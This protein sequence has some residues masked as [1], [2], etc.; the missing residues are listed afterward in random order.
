MNILGYSFTPV[1]VIHAL[2]LKS[3]GYVIVKDNKSVFFTGDVAWIEKAHLKRIGPVDLVVTEATMMQKGG[4]INR[5]ENKIYGHTGI[6]D[7]LRILSPLTKK[8]MFTHYGDWFY[9]DVKTSLEMLRNFTS[10]KLAV[11]PAHDG[12]RI[13]I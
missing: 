10:P 6:P 2:N 7:L 12:L 11:V 5:K 9:E 1:P 13:E 4:R 3:W 8:I